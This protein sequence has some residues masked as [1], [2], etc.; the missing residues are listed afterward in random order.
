MSDDKYNLYEAF[1]GHIKYQNILFAEDDR[2]H[3]YIHTHIHFR[4]EEFI[5][6]YRPMLRIHAWNKMDQ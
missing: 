5:N 2:L 4:E 6:E 1:S 3:E